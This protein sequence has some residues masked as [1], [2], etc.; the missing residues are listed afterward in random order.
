[1]GGRSVARLLLGSTGTAF[2]SSD[3]AGA[4]VSKVVSSPLRYGP[5]QQAWQVQGNAD[6]AAPATVYTARQAL[7]ALTPLDSY[8]EVRLWL[9][10]SRK[11][12]GSA[13]CPVYAS[14]QVGRGAD[15]LASWPL[16]IARSGVWELA[17]LDLSG[18]S[19]RTVDW[20]GFAW[21]DPTVSFQLIADD[22]MAVRE[23]P[24]ADADAAFLALLDG[25][26]AATDGGPPVPAAI[27]Q[28]DLDGWAE[29]ETRPYIRLIPYAIDLAR[30]RMNAGEI[31]GV[32]AAGKL[33]VS[34]PP[35]PYDLA[36]AIDVVGGTRAEKARL[37]EFLLAL[38]FPERTVWVGSELLLLQWQPAPAAEQPA[39]T[40]AGS[41]PAGGGRVAVHV[42]LRTSLQSGARRT[43]APV[44]QTA[45]AAGQPGDSGTPSA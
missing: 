21:V 32:T 41:L 2:V 36:Y 10:A 5:D 18:V 8:P 4:L 7:A 26:T 12:D 9:N 15:V 43:T 16:L 23:E 25:Q 6:L 29:P 45:L 40:S 27:W 3:G 11:A 13:D 30:D 1:M 37:Y 33:W 38:L 24:L 31:R 20:V 44:R 22:L 17:R 19:D 35:V 39:W 28:D 34:D 14:F 42:R